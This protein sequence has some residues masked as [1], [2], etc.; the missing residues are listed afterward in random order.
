MK[1]HL[2]AAAVAAAVAAPAMAQVTMYGYIE[3][4][5]QHNKPTG[6][7]GVVRSSNSTV[8]SSR[9]GITGTE[10][11]GGGLKVTF[12]LEGDVVASTGVWGGPN[13]GATTI[14]G[15]GTSGTFGG[16]SSTTSTSNAGGTIFSREASLAVQGNFGTVRLGKTDL[17]QA[18]GVDT[19]VGGAHFGNV[20][21]TSGVELGGDALSS[22]RY[23]SPTMNGVT[24]Q[25]ARFFNADGNGVATSQVKP[26][27]GTINALSV[28]Y[29]A[30]KLGL[31]AGM[32]DRD[33]GTTATEAKG[34]Q[35]FGVRYDFGVVSVGAMQGKRAIV[36][37]A[38]VTATRL[39][40]RAPLGSGYALHFAH[41]IN[42]VKGS[43][44]SNSQFDATFLGLSK[45]LS[46]RTTLYGVYGTS[47]G[48]AA[49]GSNDFK[50][51]LFNVGHSF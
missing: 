27:T 24:F 51:F 1:K 14:D 30:G 39:S 50:T 16:N 13:E 20:T 18:E 34:Y 26:S 33:E 9:L 48:E 2:I 28:A 8:G 41:N 11:L 49:T 25:V 46:K 38:D 22:V 6:G 21:N 44:A 47:D 45:A 29:T 42:K 5:I 3:T 32:E 37:G 17:G 7:E 40:A 12:T 10:D 19:F 4:G 15:T 36:S 43:V 35:A 31:I 23:I